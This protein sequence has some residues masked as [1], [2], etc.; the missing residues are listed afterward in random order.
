MSGEFS[1]L[2]IAIGAII[3]LLDLW[4]IISVYRSDKGVEAKALWSLGIALFPVL[5]LALWGLFGPRAMSPAPSSTGHS[6]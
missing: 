5:G 2:F 4:A 6:K 1:L 3:I